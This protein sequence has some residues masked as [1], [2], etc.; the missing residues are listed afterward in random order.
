MYA[1]MIKMLFHFSS[2][3][4][5][6]LFQGCNLKLCDVEQKFCKLTTFCL[7]LHITENIF[8]YSLVSNNK[9]Y[10][11]TI[12]IEKLLEIK[13]YITHNVCEDVLQDD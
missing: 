6:L 12:E 3:I 8:S 9:L 7:F 4:F 10:E 5:Q 2:H 11:F 1:L 13:M